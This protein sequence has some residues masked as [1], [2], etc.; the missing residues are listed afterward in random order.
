[1]LIKAYQ[2]ASDNVI[3][4]ISVKKINALKQNSQKTFASQENIKTIKLFLIDQ[5]FLVPKLL[6][7]R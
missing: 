2:K 7:S 5:L 4:V 3:E 1:M 6:G